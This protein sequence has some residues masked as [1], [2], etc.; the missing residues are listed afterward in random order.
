MIIRYARPDDA[1]AVYEA[2]RNEPD[3]IPWRDADECRE[4]IQWMAALGSPPIVAETEAG[5]VAEMEVWW[6]Q[7]V[8]EL[9]RTL[10]VS[11][12]E[13]HR[14]H[15]RQGI[16]TALV[17]R[18]IELSREHGCE[19]VSVW[20]D[21]RSIGFYE[22]LGF[23][24]RLVLRHYA[25][26]VAPDVETPF[27]PVRLASL[28]RPSG[29]HL[30]TRR[31]LHPKQKWHDLLWM[32]GEPPVWKGEAEPRPA[33]FAATAGP[34]IAV[35]RLQ[36]WLGDAETA[37]LYLWSPSRDAGILTSAIDHAR[38]LGITALTTYAYGQP[39]ECLAE[40]GAEIHDPEHVL[41]RPNGREGP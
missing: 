12:I 33:V 7:D 29:A 25:V 6:G 22:T 39:A 17:A 14:D 16:G 9:G 35:Y 24:R 31:L 30:Q 3:N 32:E 11:M 21:R 23:E 41:V 2:H 19:C 13:V 26:G 10:D 38:T 36:H 4:H 28:E 15:Q 37:E 18:A 40:L 20:A 1:E 5:V 27:E 8:P 34:A